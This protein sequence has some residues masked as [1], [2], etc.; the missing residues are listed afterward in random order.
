MPLDS[1]SSQPVL[2]RLESELCRDEQLLARSKAGDRDALTQLLLEHG[3]H[4]RA[5]LAIGP[6]W[7][8]LLEPSDVMQVT[9]FEAFEQI[10]GFEGDARTFP[11]WL[12]RIAENNLRD[13]IQW[14]EREK[15][16]QP[17]HRVAP[18]SNDDGIA[19]LSEYLSG[20]GRSPSRHAMGNETLELLQAEIDHLP[21]DYAYVLRRIFIEG[22]PVGD[23]AQ[24]M[25]KT[26]G[27]VHLIRIRALKR[28]R[29]RL[30]SGTKFFSH[31]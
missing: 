2:Q 8:A 7:R 1:H 27:A 16:P 28:L 23:V 13:A 30:G 3:P 9:Y 10:T 25:N 6:K 29:D 17:E 15:R 24:S 26:K 4:V 18:P 12:R 11:R 22:R 14:F 20:H 31:H 5:T 19:W 21:A